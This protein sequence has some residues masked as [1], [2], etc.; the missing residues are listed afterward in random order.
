MEGEG[1]KGVWE[2]MDGERRWREG[3]EKGRERA[4]MR[5]R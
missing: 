4:M 3:K 5:G 2:G 1:A